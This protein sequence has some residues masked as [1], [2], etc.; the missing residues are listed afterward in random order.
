M[1]IRVDIEITKNHD[2]NSGEEESCGQGAT[3]GGG[4]TG[5]RVDASNR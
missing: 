2:K 1:T 5:G 3:H 4:S